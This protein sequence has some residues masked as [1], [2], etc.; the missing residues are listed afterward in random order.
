MPGRA[1]DHMRRERSTS[2]DS[3]SWCWTRSSHARHGASIEDIETIVAATPQRARPCASATLDGLVGKDSEKVTRNPQGQDHQRRR[4]HEHP[5]ACALVDDVR[6]Q[7]VACRIT[8]C[9]TSASTRRLVFTAT[10]RDADSIAAA[11]DAASPPWRP[12]W[13]HAP[14][15]RDRMLNACAGSK[16]GAGGH[17][18]RGTRNRRADSP[19]GV[20]TST[21][22]IARRLRGPHRPA[23]AAPAAAGRDLPGP[24]RGK[25]AAREHRALHQQEIAVGCRRGDATAADRGCLRRK[26]RAPSRATEAGRTQHDGSAGRTHD[27]QGKLESRVRRYERESPSVQRI[28]DPET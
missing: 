9:A 6:Q 15:R 13:R 21:C 27:A 12:A 14:G 5:A 8:S 26:R 19:D 18:R 2:P 3:R 24:S 7:G 4:R 11:D 28:V 20:S 10:K 1:L 25:R 16:S 22:P 23:P 17:R